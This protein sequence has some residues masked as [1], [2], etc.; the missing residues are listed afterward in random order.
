MPYFSNYPSPFNSKRGPMI[1]IFIDNLVKYFSDSTHKNMMTFGPES[2]GS[3]DFQLKAKRLS[4]AVSLSLLCSESCLNLSVCFPW[5]FTEMIQGKK[6]SY[7][8]IHTFKLYFFCNRVEMSQDHIMLVLK[9]CLYIIKLSHSVLFMRKAGGAR[10][11][12]KSTHADSNRA[13]LK[14]ACDFKGH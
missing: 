13:D 6:K 1:L 8:S 3:L 12:L 10:K 7:C 4:K 14:I 2:K 5:T 11:P 9:Q